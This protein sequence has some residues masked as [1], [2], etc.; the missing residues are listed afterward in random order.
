MSLVQ[1]H[2]DYACMA[3][4]YNLSKEFK[5]KLQVVQNN[6]MR[7]ILHKGHREHIGQAEFKQIKF[8][9]IENR[10]KQLGLNIVHKLFYK[11]TPGYLL[12]YF[13]RASEV[14]N[15]NTRGSQ[16][17]FKIPTATNNSIASNSFSFNAIKAWN[18][19]PN[20]IKCIQQYLNFKT[21][22]KSHLIN[23]TSLA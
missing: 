3:W 6:M 18:A 15:Y 20:N 13:V 2:I 23:H 14:H 1:C 12:S 16:F 21:R 4:Y 17:N 8:V 10:V 22:L 19:L 9:N 5:H 11:Q 7:L